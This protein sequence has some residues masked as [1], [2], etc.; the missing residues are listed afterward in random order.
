MVMRKQIQ[1]GLLFYDPRLTF[2]QALLWALGKAE[3]VVCK[4]GR[5]T[6]VKIGISVFLLIYINI[7]KLECWTNLSEKKIK[8]EI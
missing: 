2:D 8:L 3:F 5:V 1:K 7:N 6:W 4:G